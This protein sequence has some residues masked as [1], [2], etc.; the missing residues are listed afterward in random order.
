ML[1]MTTIHQTRVLA[2]A[3]NNMEPNKTN[4][5]SHMALIGSVII[6]LIVIIISV[7]AVKQYKEVKIEED[8]IT[9]QTQDTYIES[10]ATIND[11]SDLKSI[12]ADLEMTDIDNLGE[13]L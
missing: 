1:L 3:H 8:V 2:I 10:Q 5:N 13:G 4:N 12:E 6:V 7:F 11:S 9:T